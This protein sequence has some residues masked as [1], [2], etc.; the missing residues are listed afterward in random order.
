MNSRSH[1]ASHHEHHGGRHNRPLT[2]WGLVVAWTAGAPGLRAQ[3]PDPLGPLVAEALRNNLALAAERRAEDRTAA[4]VKEARGLFFPSATV[5]SRYTEQ[6]GTVNLGD[7]VNPAYAALNQIRGRNQFPTNLDLTLPLAYESRVRVIQPLFNES[8]RKNYALARHRLDGQREQTGIAARRLAADVQTAY[9]SVADARS[10]VAIY[11]ASLALV[12]ESERVATRLL[13]AG[14]AT[15]DAVFR[16]R[17]E[18]SDVEQKLAEAT[19][20]AEAAARALNQ[21]VGRPLDTPV[22]AIPDSA[23][24]F[25]LG[26][27]E[28]E[29]VAHALAHREELS[30]VDAGIAAADEAVGL[31]TAAFLPSV[32]LAFDYGFQGQE[33]RFGPNNDYWTVSVVLSWNLFNGGRDLSRR[34][35]AGAEAARARLVRQDLEEKIRLEVRQAYAAALVA[36]AAIA[37]ADD[38]LAAARR[39]FDLVR[40]RYEEGVASQIEFLD[41]RTQ[42]TNAELNRALTAHRF[43]IRYFNLERAAALRA[44]D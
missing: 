32:A 15:P 33:I 21:L 30:A 29:A 26:L 3:Q 13:E 31:A 23:L 11:H 24:Q 9:V 6:S 18:R 22:P 2:F 28:D 42:L 7:F 17:A 38:R 20:Q 27:S 14:R 37:T 1:D 19:E 44:I 12:A 43:A 10:A 5:D 40:R 34:Q 41:A 16:A 25:E 8:I 39:T 35:A 36:Q 4:Q